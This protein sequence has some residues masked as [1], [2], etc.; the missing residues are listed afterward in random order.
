MST[1]WERPRGGPRS[2]GRGLLAFALAAALVAAG[3]LVVDR[4][5]LQAE[6]WQVRHTV[7]A[8]PVAPQPALGPP[9]GPLAVSWQRTAQVRR[10][11][12]AG[13]GTVAYDVAQG[14]VV[15]ASGRGLEVRDARTGA[16]RWSYRRTGWTMLGWAATGSRLVGHFERDGHR[17][18]RQLVG[19][20]ALSGGVLWRRAGDRP[21]A[22]NRDTLRW[23]AG[24]GVVLTTDQER[25]VLRGRAAADG[26]KAWTVRLPAG[27]RLFEDAAHT[28]DGT[29]KLVALAIDCAGGSRL[30]AID[31]ARGRQR[32]VRA[33]G[34]AESPEV[35]MLDGV[36]LAA[37]GTALRAYDREGTQFA[38]WN[39]AEVC[40]DGMC[41]AALVGGRLIVVRDPDGDG[42]GGL[43]ESVA[44]PS[45]RTEWK[46][47]VPGYVALTTAAGR[48]YALRP[49]LDERL[50]PAGVDVVEPGDGTATTAPAPFAMDPVL[51]GVRPWLAAA[52]GLL[53]VAVPEAA[54]R[55]T[56]SARLIALRGGAAGPGPAEL[57]GVAEADWPDACALLKALDLKGEY[58]ARPERATLEG[59]RLPH[60]VSCT[61]EPEKQPRDKDK[62]K[63]KAKGEEERGDAG[64][65]GSPRPSASPSGD[66]SP[67][68]SPVPGPVPAT[69]PGWGSR[70]LTVT[71]KWVAP[72]P[73]GASAML[74]TLQSTQSKARRRTDIGG[75]EAYEIGPAAS[76][77]A[78]RVDRYIVMVDAARP[79]GA[80]TRLA[81]AVAAHLPRSR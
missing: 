79:P 15:T 33:L 73:G 60:P 75:D 41:P 44:V 62:A 34:S 49:K 55:P 37:D 23:P 22:A 24:A 61:Y 67:G 39:G 13:Y 12:Q 43:M 42:G 52:G 11:P 45:G 21:A 76:M 3:G 28:S 56:G 59:V 74:E 2:V 10:G 66:A 31:P 54:P 48:L 17:G 81:K 16:A 25:R 70:G 65:S 68:R 26:K 72:A 19:F 9:A 14:Q 51:G 27:C 5:V 36:T 53:Y 46:R 38:V 6:W 64:T 47:D 58:V 69:V 20:D 1:G 30:L 80:A 77:I 78:L 4:F 29:E 71:V 32:W 40:A 8:E 50:L 7:T 63:D 18:E 35:R 57:G